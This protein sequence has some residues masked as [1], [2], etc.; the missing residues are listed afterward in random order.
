MRVFRPGRVPDPESGRRGIFRGRAD[1]G[2]D[3][4]RPAPRRAPAKRAPRSAASWL[5]IFPSSSSGDRAVFEGIV[6]PK[7]FFQSPSQIRSRPG[8]AL[9]AAEPTEAWPGAVPRRDRLERSEPRAPRLL[10]FGSSLLA[11]AVIVGSSRG[12]SVKRLPVPEGLD[13][14]DNT[15]LKC[16]S[17]CSLNIYMKCPDRAAAKIAQ[18]PALELKEY[19][20]HLGDREDHLAVGYVQ[21]KC[22]P[23]P[24]A[25]FP[26]PLGVARR[27]KP[28]GLT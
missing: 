22:L 8:A 15:G 12:S 14:G 11:Q 18:E 24:F 28:P 13:D 1:G 27:T 19:P 3:K 25:P 2:P 9:S 21:K 5:W 6:G 16:Y 7:S 26:K 10:G 17:R 20:E 23:H 4:R